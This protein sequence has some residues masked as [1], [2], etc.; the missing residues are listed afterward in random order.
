MVVILA[1][2][3]NKPNFHVTHDLLVDNGCFY[4]AIKVV[5]KG[6]WVRE[7]VSHC[8]KLLLWIY[9]SASILVQQIWYNLTFCLGG[10]ED[11]AAS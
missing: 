11:V 2:L 10:A 5:R 6:P 1:S 7:A 3:P 4:N 8:G 9:N